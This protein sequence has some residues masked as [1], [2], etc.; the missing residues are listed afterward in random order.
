M[1]VTGRTLVHHMT[2]VLLSFSFLIMWLNAFMFTIRYGE[3]NRAFYGLSPGLIETCIAT[4]GVNNNESEPFFIK[5]QLEDDV[6]TYLMRELNNFNSFTVS[7]YYYVP[8]T[9]M[10]CSG[11]YCQGV[12]IKLQSRVNSFVKY[13]QKL[14]YEIIATL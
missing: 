9:R 13:E 7:F 3:I 5:P 14:Q 12:A 1:V 11:D 4:P 8:T 2:N 10:Y 6:V